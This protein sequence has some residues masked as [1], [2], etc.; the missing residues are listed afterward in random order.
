[1]QVE[2]LDRR[3]YRTAFMQVKGQIETAVTNRLS[4]LDKFKSLQQR[5]RRMSIVAPV[6]DKDNAIDFEERIAVCK[7]KNAHRSSA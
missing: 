7:I 4:S 2:G 6:N 1:M 3:D 5:C